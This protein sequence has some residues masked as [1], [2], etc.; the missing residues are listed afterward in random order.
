MPSSIPIFWLYILT[1]WIR[2]TNSFSFLLS[3]GCKALCIVIF[4][5]LMSEFFSCPVYNW[6]QYLYTNIAPMFI[7]LMRFLL[8]KLSRSSDVLFSDLFFHLGLFSGVPFH[9]FPSTCNFPFLQ[10]FWFF[11]NLVVLFLPLFVFFPLFVMIMVDFQYQIDCQ[12]H[13]NIFVLFVSES[14]Y[15]SYFANSLLSSV[16]VRWEIFFSDFVSL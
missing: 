1:A 9:N 16:Y 13:G 14:P 15:F 7:A 5:V 3:L 11:L 10:S 2:F 6:P 4:F 12:Y 8:Q